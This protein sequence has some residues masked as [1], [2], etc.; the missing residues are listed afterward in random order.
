[1]RALRLVLLSIAALLGGLYLIFLAYLWFNQERLIFHPYPLEK[2][3]QFAFDSSFEE[4]DIPS[5][6]NNK[7]NGLLFKTEKPKGLIFYLHGN[8]GALDSWGGIAENYTK[9]GYDIFILD[10]RGFGKSEGKIESEQQMNN[11]VSAAYRYLLKRYPENKTV[12]IGYSIGTGPAA[13]LASQDHPDALILQAP[14]YS[15]SELADAQVPLVPDFVKKYH[16]E[17]YK[18]LPQVKCPVYLFHGDADQLI[19]LENSVRL[20][21]LLPKNGRFITLKGQPHQGVNENPDYLAE[22]AHILNQLNAKPL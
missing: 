21:K 9:L 13:Y 3:Y 8:A 7:L 17:T 12:V 5:Y 14:Y 10:Y 18:R 22:L 20:S 15:L 6:D 2:D 19:A 1:M 11:D 16:F 4:L